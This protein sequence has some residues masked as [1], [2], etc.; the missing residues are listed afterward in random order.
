MLTDI[1]YDVV[2]FVVVVALATMVY[3]LRYRRPHSLTMVQKNILATN[4]GSFTTLYALF[5]GLAVVTLLQTYNDVE[6][7]ATDEADLLLTQYDI[8]KD[9]GNS[10]PFRMAV[11][12]Y[13]AYVGGQGWKNMRQGLPSDGAQALYRT[14]WK[15]LRAMKP[16]NSEDAYLYAFM[17]DKMVSID[18]LRHKRILAIAGN[19][20]APIWVLVFT[21][22][23]FTI[24]GF[25][26]IDSGH[27]EADIYYIA[28]VL[29]LILGSI[30]LLYELD[31]PFS[32]VISIGPERF[33]AAWRA[34]S[35]P[36]GP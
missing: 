36:A 32:G 25:Y 31:T 10:E 5:L 30:F 18:K 20:Y 16:K 29:S 13:T 15:A 12:E 11:T 6:A 34:M 35:A 17:L 19:L 21:G 24:F 22:L 27:N 26:Y 1:R 7:A 2:V 4:Y 23:L 33:E 14:A 9:L 3:T 8:S 28:M